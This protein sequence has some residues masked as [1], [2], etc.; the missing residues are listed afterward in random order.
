MAAGPTLTV[1]YFALFRSLAKKSEEPL[2]FADASAL[3]SIP[4]LYDALRARYGFPLER[5]SVH[6][7]VNDAYVSWDHALKS[8]DRVVFIPPVSGG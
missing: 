4:A 5:D 8:G 3:A 6:V 7:A 1:E 2:E